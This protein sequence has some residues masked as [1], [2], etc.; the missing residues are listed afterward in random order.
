MVMTKQLLRKYWLNVLQF[1]GVLLFSISLRPEICSL[2]ENAKW[3][4]ICFFVFLFLACIY[5]LPIRIGI[6]ERFSRKRITAEVMIVWIIPMVLGF[7]ISGL[8][9]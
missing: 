4:A 5:E 2:S 9:S 8:L 6:K 1:F 7:W 3:V